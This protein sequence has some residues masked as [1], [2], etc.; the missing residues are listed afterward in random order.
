MFEDIRLRVVYNSRGE[1]TLEAETKINNEKIKA[2]YPSG[3]SKSSK[4]AVSFPESPEKLIA[5]NKKI[6]RKLEGFELGRQKEFDGM[7]EEI[8]GTNNFSNIG[9]LSLV[10]SELYLKASAKNENLEPW[11]YLNKKSRKAPKIPKLLGN[12]LG[13]GK[14]FF[15][16]NKV[17][18]QEFLVFSNRV[19]SVWEAQEKNLIIYKRVCE[20]LKKDRKF[21]GK[22]DENALFG[23][24]SLKHALDL[25][26]NI[27]LEYRNLGFGIDVAATCFFNNKNKT[28]EY[29]DGMIRKEE[30]QLEFM[31][32]LIESGFTYLEDPFEENDFESFSRLTKEKGKKAMICGDDLFSTNPEILERGIKQG[33]CNAIIIKPN[34]AG[35]ITRTVDVVRKAKENNYITIVSHRSGETEDTIIADLGAG[36][37][38]DFIKTGIVGGERTSKINRLIEIEEKL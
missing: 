30:G 17:D 23:D 25:V 21:F 9:A 32:F 4:E 1:K 18:F 2:S 15:I 33:A 20:I 29:Y 34:Q 27:R 8:D 22:N 24:I 31:R 10:L 12:F 13:G 26:E 6:L 3:K 36:L 37:E 11:Q 19:K 5:N 35:T 16:N 28:Y 38:M 14:H 7:L